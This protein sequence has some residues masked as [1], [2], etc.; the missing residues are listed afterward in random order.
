MYC[1]TTIQQ[2]ETRCPRLLSGINWVSISFSYIKLVHN[3]AAI[4]NQWNWLKAKFPLYCGTTIQQKET[5]CPSFLSGINWV[6]IFFSYIKLPHNSAAIGNQWNWLKAEFPLYCGTTIQQKETRC[7]RLLS[8]I[9]WVSISFSYIK[10]VHNSAAIGN[11]WST[12]FNP[13]IIFSI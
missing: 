8:G 6:S 11:W 13:P 12:R 1:G 2:K 10:L 4:G 9:N 5:R 3:S 7:P